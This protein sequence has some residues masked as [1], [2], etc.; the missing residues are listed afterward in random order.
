MSYSASRN[1]HLASLPWAESMWR[2][3][4]SAVWSVRTVKWVPS[5]KGRKTKRD[6]RTA[7]HSLYV[8]L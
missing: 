8:V 3:H 1:V 2:I 4:L 6:Q 7:R 5:R